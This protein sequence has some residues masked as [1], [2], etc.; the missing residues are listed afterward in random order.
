ML[1]AAL[2]ALF[3]APHNPCEVSPVRLDGTVVTICATETPGDPDAARRLRLR[4]RG[5]VTGVRMATPAEV[6]AQ[7]DRDR[8]ALTCR[9]EADEVCPD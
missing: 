5:K 8:R 3:V 4:W 9:P 7:R 2:L 6:A 1:T